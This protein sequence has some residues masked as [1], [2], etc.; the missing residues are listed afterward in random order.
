MLSIEFIDEN[1]TSSIIEWNED[2]RILTVEPKAKISFK[3]K[4]NEDSLDNL[5]SMNKASWALYNFNTLSPYLWSSD[6]KASF[7]HLNSSYQTGFTFQV[8]KLDVEEEIVYWIEAI[9]QTKNSKSSKK[10]MKKK[11][12]QIIIHF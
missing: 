3:V 12:D 6:K 5:T 1:K 7:E 4:Q 10:E 11:I 2:T 8:D 9:L